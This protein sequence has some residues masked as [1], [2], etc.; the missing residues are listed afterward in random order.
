MQLKILLWVQWTRL[1]VRGL[2]QAHCAPYSD[3]KSWEPWSCTEV[4]DCPQTQASNIIWVQKRCPINL[5]SDAPFPQPSICLSKVPVNECPPG[6]PVGAIWRQLPF[7]RAFFYMSLEFLI[8]TFLIKRNF[9]LLSKALGQECPPM[10]P[11]T[12]PLWKEVPIS[13]AFLSTSFGIP[14]KGDLPPGSPHT[15]PTERDVL[16]P[17]HSYSE[18]TMTSTQSE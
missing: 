13:I 8:K 17:E 16:F 14:S 6:S 15:A 4:T 3:V 18:F 5:T 12:G 2:K 1:V 11:K 10:F 9:I 7:S